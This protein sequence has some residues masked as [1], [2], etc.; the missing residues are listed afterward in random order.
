MF[1]NA[2]KNVNR[3]LAARGSLRCSPSPRWV[4]KIH[5]GPEPSKKSVSGVG[6]ALAGATVA[7]AALYA[8]SGKTLFS[9]PF[10]GI[11]FEEKENQDTEEYVHLP[12]EEVKKSVVEEILEMRPVE[13]FE[14]AN[15]LLTELTTNL[16]LSVFAAVSLNS[17][18][19]KSIRALEDD[20]SIF[21]KDLSNSTSHDSG[22]DEA[23][24]RLLISD[25][26]LQLTLIKA[27]KTTLEAKD[28][29]EALEGILRELCCSKIPLSEEVI[30]KAENGLSE[31]RTELKEAE[32][33]L[34]LSIKSTGPPEALLSRV[35]RLTTDME[36]DLG[37]SLSGLCSTETRELY[38]RALALHLEQTRRSTE[39][40]MDELGRRSSELRQF[41]GEGG[42]RRRLDALLN[43]KEEELRRSV[44]EQNHFQL[45]QLKK[46]L[47]HQI[48]E[49]KQ[50]SIKGAALKHESV[51]R[52]RS[53]TF[54]REVKDKVKKAKED[55]D[56]WKL[57]ISQDL[58]ELGPNMKRHELNLKKL[59][60]A[61]T[62]A[63]ACFRLE[64]ALTSDPFPQLDWKHQVQPIKHHLQQ[65]SDNAEGK[66][67]FVRAVID[68]VPV[69]A[70]NR[71]V[72]TQN[73][74]RQRF[75]EMEPTAR[76]VSLLKKRDHNST[77]L[78][79]M[80]YLRS[81]LLVRPVGCISNLEKTNQ[82]VQIG[83]LTN[84]ELLDRAR[85]FMELGD[86]RQAASYVNMLQGVAQH[87]SSGWAEEVVLHLTV[88]QA[89]HA[90]S[91]IA[92]TIMN[93]YNQGVKTD[94]D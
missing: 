92:A 79:L 32:D 82:P 83:D 53:F 34:D 58:A 21:A 57:E 65:M 60:D 62:F 74:L 27:Q 2:S 63:N 45:N 71:G 68:S 47:E 72:Y 24:L 77:I 88:S 59:S 86:L 52:A 17:L 78:Y 42:E 56:K 28:R 46:K 22:S 69:A 36:E 44:Q 15:K 14:A 12:V 39:R 73:A 87:V 61:F 51:L 23:V 11:L 70:I 29:L 90:L 3:L 50:A 64:S 26:E 16:G 9:L 1:S 54:D 18:A 93:Q 20:M 7:S 10:I 4:N 80:S 55:L 85:Y 49:E 38:N 35:I 67:D 37:F 19:A 6:F 89:A 40:Q 84:E 5:R 75:F 30:E 41:V 94:V 76:K 25:K 31:A 66:R 81:I 8:R 33:F 13:R 91:A 43:S 48:L